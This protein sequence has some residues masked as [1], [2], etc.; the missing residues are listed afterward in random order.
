MKA[1]NEMTQRELM[2]ESRAKVAPF[3]RWLK[4]VLRGLL[5]APQ[6]TFSL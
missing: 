3:A 4:K 5:K 1:A 6:A 2:R